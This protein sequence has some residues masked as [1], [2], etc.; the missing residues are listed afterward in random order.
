MTKFIPLFNSEYINLKRSVRREREQLGQIFN[1]QENCLNESEKQFS[2]TLML[3]CLQTWK[4]NSQLI[5]YEFY[6]PDRKGH[7]TTENQT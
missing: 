1:D 7:T 4:L 5:F 2:F 6:K 3:S